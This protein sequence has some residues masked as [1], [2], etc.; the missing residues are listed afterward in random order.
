LSQWR[1][2]VPGKDHEAQTCDHFAEASPAAVVAMAWFETA[3]IR[4]GPKMIE[5]SWFSAD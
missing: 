5:T 2:I 4:N 3:G 1:K